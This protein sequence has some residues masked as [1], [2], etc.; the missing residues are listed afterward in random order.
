M[1]HLFKRLAWAG[2]ICFLLS[3]AVSATAETEDKVD[4]DFTRSVE[5]QAYYDQIQAVLAQKKFG[6]KEKVKGW[7]LKNQ[8][9]KKKDSS[10]LKDLV[11]SFGVSDG[12][13]YAVSG[14][15][16]VLLWTLVIGLIVYL[17]VKYRTQIKHLVN[18]LGAPSTPELPATM[19]GLDV[20]KNSMPE[21]VVKSARVLWDADEHRQAVA[22]L[23]RASLIKLLHEHHC[24]FLDSDTEAEYCERLEKQV[25]QKLS[26][27]MHL[28]VQVWQQVAY[29]HRVPADGVFN[30]LCQQWQEVF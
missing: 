28:L 1:T 30:S 25:P 12:F 27:Y 5:A 15:I 22:L 2:V 26:Q 8:D 10:R 24:F 6:G 20:K 3:F 21:D 18:D 17:L 9:K 11:R 4:A 16:E 13:V 19:F 7:R 23:L 14:V 29:A